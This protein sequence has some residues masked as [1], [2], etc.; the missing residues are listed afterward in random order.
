LPT[1][2]AV[3]VC[4]SFGGVRAVD[5]VSFK[6]EEDKISGF[7][8]PNGAG[9]TTLFNLMTGFLPLDK[10]RLIYDSE[11]ITN[12]APHRIMRRGISRS[13]QQVRLFEELT[14]LENVLVAL[15]KSAGDNPIEALFPWGKIGRRKRGDLEKALSYLE[16]VGLADAA[17]KDVK[18]LAF[19]EQKL[20]AIARLLATEARLLLLDEPMSG[21]DM[22]VLENT[23]LPLV[24][25]LVTLEKK[26]ICII[27]HSIE[28]I[29]KLCNWCFFLNFGRLLAQGEPQDLIENPEL[30]KIYFGSGQ[31]R[32]TGRD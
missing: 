22:K 9:K 23:L 20:V 12:W 31:I 28:V 26:T 19:P 16:F 25:R 1:F 21:L 7:I 17:N 15:P 11:V 3:D 14:V 30:T 18:D 10:G 5:H 4:K 2:E 24:N 13:W 32:I 6:L 29:K 8:G 27:E